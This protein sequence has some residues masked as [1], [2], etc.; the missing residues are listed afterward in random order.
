MIIAMSLPDPNA[1]VKAVLNLS[2]N[3]SADVTLMKLMRTKCTGNIY[4]VTPAPTLTSLDALILAYENAHGPARPVTLVPLKA[5]LEAIMLTFQLFANLPAN[6]SNSIVIIQSGGFHV[7]GVGGSHA[8]IWEVLKSNVAG[9]I[10]MTFVFCA[11]PHCY[12]VWYSTD[13]IAWVRAEP[14]IHA[15]ARIG[16]LVPDSYVWVRYQLILDSG[17]QGG[18]IPLRIQVPA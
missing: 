18:Y 16:G 5:A 14:C 1:V 13:G 8:Q 6:K 17:G 3:H 9:E 11:A 10:L 4:V 15:H 7:M 12:D 2:G